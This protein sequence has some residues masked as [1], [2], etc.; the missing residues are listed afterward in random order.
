MA[1][2][3][4]TRIDTAGEHRSGLRG[5]LI[6]LLIVC[7][8]LGVALYAGSVSR[9]HPSTSDASI[10][11]EVVHVAPNVGGRV[12]EIGVQETSIVRKDDILFQIDPQPYQLIVNQSQ[13]D[14]D[15]AQA[16]LDTAMRTVAKQR[17]NARIAR[18]ETTTARDKYEL[19]TRNVERLK[20]LASNGYAT[21]QQLDQ[22]NVSVH[23]AGTQLSQARVQE[24]A[25]L[26]SVDTLKAAESAV[27]ARAAALELARRNLRDTTVRAPH[28]GLVVGLTVS[29]GE[30]VAPGQALFTLLNSEE[31]YAIANFRETALRAVRPGDCATVH[32][33]LDRGLAVRG[34]VQGIGWGVTNQDL[35]NLPRSAPYVEPTLNWVQVEQRFPVRIRLENPPQRVMR[36]GASAVVEIKHGSQCP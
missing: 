10:S 23:E 2:P 25:A 26:E 16:Q 12:I 4:E 9:Q 20:P 30:F 14:L 22:A 11:A 24:L 17:A 34:V 15:A 29:S 32:S 33:M 27:A 6:V 21:S 36:L 28:E 18:D 19:A 1:A 35:V 3:P 13:A 31:W 7:L 8:A 5:K